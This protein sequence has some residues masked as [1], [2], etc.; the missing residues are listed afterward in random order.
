MGDMTIKKRS[1]MRSSDIHQARVPV[2]EDEE[3]VVAEAAQDAQ[4]SAAE[5]RT[6]KLQLLAS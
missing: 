1:V 6:E 3:I 5:G 4:L 2:A